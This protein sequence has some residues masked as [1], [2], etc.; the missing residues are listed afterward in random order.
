MEY[1]NI[2]LSLPKELL[3]KVK[4]LAVERQTSVSGLL[5]QTLEN[6]VRQEEAYSHARQRHLQLL[7]RGT[8]LGTG[9]RITTKRDELHERP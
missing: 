8:N 2:T 4:H 1:Q 3:L 7:E 9:G 6:L 5:A